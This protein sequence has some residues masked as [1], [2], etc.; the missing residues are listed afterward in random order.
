MSV[1]VEARVRSA[2]AMAR[3][4]PRAVGVGRRQVVGVARSRRS[5][6][7]RRGLAP[8]AAGTL[9][10]LEHEHPGALA[11][12]RS[13]RGAR[14]TGARC[15]VATASSAAKAARESGVSAASEPPV[16]DRVGVAVLDHPQRGA[17]RVRAG[18]AGRHHAERPGRAGRG[19]ATSAAAP[20]LPII[21]GTASGETARAPLRGGS[22]GCPRSCRCRR[23]PVPMTQPMRSGS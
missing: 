7:R 20:A 11:D 14:R 3:A 8:R 23:C 12:A 19:A 5:R 22:R 6:R 1:G 15:P 4:P 9:G 21:S 10:V 18:R 2:S 17:D 13:R 16:E